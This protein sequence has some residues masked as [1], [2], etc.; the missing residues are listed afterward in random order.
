MKQKVAQRLRRAK[1]R[2]EARHAQVQKSSG[3][4][5]PVF[6]AKNIKYEVGGRD[7]GIAMGGIGAVQKFVK[8]IGLDKTI[9]ENLHLL[10]FHKPY[11]ESDHVLNFTYNALCGGK[12]IDDIDHMRNDEIFLDAI[13]AAAVP[14]PTTA[15]DFC[16][17]F[18]TA[19]LHSF[20]DIINQKRRDIWAGQNP[21]FFDIAKV[22]ADGS[23]VPTTGETK[24]GMDISYKGIWGYHPLLISL[25]NT[26]EP[27][28]IVN[29]SG[30]VPSHD[31]AAHYLDKT[32]ALLKSANFR[33]I[34]LRG[35]TDFSLTAHLDRWDNQGVYFVFGYDAKKNLIETAELF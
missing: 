21:E 20:M 35:D 18:K 15:G 24:K 33:K 6:S 23:I 3:S 14:D 8:K 11:H 12:V 13:G 34:L 19:D 2:I 28:F 32:I 5:S 10:K 27:L 16:R 29:R 4:S 1:E 9:D 7:G 31:Q 17:R 26:G 25:A 30:N 22:D